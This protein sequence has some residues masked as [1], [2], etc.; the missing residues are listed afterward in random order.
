[1]SE[2]AEPDPHEVLGVPVGSDA[3]AVRAAWRRV[4]RQCHPD[5]GGDAEAFRRARVAFE[6]LHPG[7]GT[8]PTVV[9]RLSPAG[10]AARW[11]QRRQDRA[12]QP[13]VS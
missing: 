13:R 5:R 8:G 7:A 9:R 12:Q 3:A 10:V 4:A 1:M 11:W 6:H 2:A